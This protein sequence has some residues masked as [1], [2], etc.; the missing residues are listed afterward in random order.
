MTTT[1]HTL[2]IPHTAASTAAADLGPL[3]RK[4]VAKRRFATLAT[5]SAE[6]R[7]HSA[8][9]LYAVAD[10]ALWISTYRDSRKARN[11]AETATVA[12]TVPVRR[13]PVGPPS[14][15]QLQARAS[16]VE[17]DDPELRRLA[18]TG[19]LKA[20]TSH[21]ELELDGGCMLRV[22][23]PRRVPTYGLGMSLVTLLRN[24][25]DAARTAEVD[26]S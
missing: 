25:V 17:L 5:V 10:G 12:V 7:A 15:V 20:V 16:V 14:S 13:L 26:W 1:T 11:V 19:A 23:L 24:P 9:V 18:A 6:G 21:G 4:I 8:G 3:V 2:S 22:E